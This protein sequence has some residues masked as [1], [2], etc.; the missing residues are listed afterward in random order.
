MQELGYRDLG[1]KLLSKDPHDARAVPLLIELNTEAALTKALNTCDEDLVMLVLLAKFHE[2]S[3]GATADHY[4]FLAAYCAEHGT[5]APL[6][7]WHSFVQAHN[8]PLP[9]VVPVRT[10]RFLSSSS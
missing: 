1:G 4:R 7:M 8:L 2:P 9:S 5:A 10:P 3:D 6:D